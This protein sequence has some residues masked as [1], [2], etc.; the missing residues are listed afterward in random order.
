MT[1]LALLLLVVAPARPF[2]F[3][4]GDYVIEEL[5]DENATTLPPFSI[6]I[7]RAHV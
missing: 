4:G 3:S 1:G 7:G 5:R 6:K 2:H